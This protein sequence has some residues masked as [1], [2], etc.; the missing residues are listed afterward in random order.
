MNLRALE[1][2]RALDVVYVLMLDEIEGPR[3]R[4][5]EAWQEILHRPLDPEEA[6]EYD[7]ERWGTSREAVEAA[8]AMD[9]MFSDVTYGDD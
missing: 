8:E 9:R 1:F 3:P 6:A 4:V 7:R 2:P 5:R